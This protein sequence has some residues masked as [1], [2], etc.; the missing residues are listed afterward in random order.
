MNFNG[1]NG[2]TELFRGFIDSGE[3]HKGKII[4]KKLYENFLKDQDG[5][6]LDIIS[7]NGDGAT[8]TLLSS[9][10]LVRNG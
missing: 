1:P 3:T 5:N 9:R 8:G 6:V 10:E 7:F 4:A 2:P